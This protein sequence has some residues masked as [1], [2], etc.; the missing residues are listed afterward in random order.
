MAR[1]LKKPDDLTAWEAV[2]RAFAS[3]R[4][5]DPRSLSLGVEEATKA[6]AIAPDY[7]VAHAMLAVTSAL[8]YRM[9]SPDDPAVVQRITQSIDRALAID[10]ENP[11]V[12]T[13]VAQALNMIGRPQDGLPR[14]ERAIR[15]A[16]GFGYAHFVCAVACTQLNRFEEALRHL[17]ADLKWSPVS[18]LEFANPLYR[19]AAYIG[20]GN[21]NLALAALDRLI[22]IDADASFSYLYKALVLDQMGNDSE[23]RAMMLRARQA[24]PTAQQDLWALGIERTF[25]N[26]AGQ[27]DLLASFRRLWAMTEGGA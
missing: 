15:T 3:F 13:Y 4:Q 27:G 8:R 24:E 25:Q 21:W 9:Q 22:T 2:S 11:A 23:A 6:V 7:G 16:P 10:P 5:L 12:L 26:F 14:A 18:P 19:A 1:A 17:D 20:I